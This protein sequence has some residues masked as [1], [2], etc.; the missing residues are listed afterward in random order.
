LEKYLGFQ[1][2][3]KAEVPEH[4]QRVVRTKGYGD[5]RNW[6][7]EEDVDKY[8]KMI[9]PWLEKYGYDANDWQ[10]NPAPVI[11]AS[12]CSE[13]FMRLVREQRENTGRNDVVLTTVPQP[14][15]VNGRIVRAEPR[16][17]AGWAIGPEVEKPV[18]VALLLN[19]TQIA[20]VEANRLRPGLQKRG[21]HPTGECGFVFRFGPDESLPVGAKVVVQPV[22]GNGVIKNSPCIIRDPDQPS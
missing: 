10:L 19:G 13:Y 16:V 18:R 21:L 14:A 15:V 4:F 20:Q 1:V 7:T 22:S 11:D 17:I 6:F 9:S 12:H 5:W 3:G 2:A 8:R